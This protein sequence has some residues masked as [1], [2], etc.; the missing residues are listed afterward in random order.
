MDGTAPAPPPKVLVVE[1]EQD[2]RSMV[3]EVLADEGY[4]AEQA[5]DGRCAL[6]VLQGAGR[7]PDVVLLDLMMP[8]MDGWQFRRLQL[9]DPRLAGIPVIA[10]SA[11]DTSAVGADAE[12]AKPFDIEQL[13]AA[14]ERVLRRPT[15]H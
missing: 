3:S 14:M 12:L 15:L 10:M 8:G 5:E 1:D 6:L 11:V 13:L 7:S 9:A 2:L 4:E